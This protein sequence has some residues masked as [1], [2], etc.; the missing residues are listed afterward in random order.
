MKR[1]F[2]YAAAA[3]L[4]ALSI[5]LTAQGDGQSANAYKS[6]QY[7]SGN[8][9]FTPAKNVMMGGEFLWGHRDNFSDGFSSNDYRLQF[10]FKYSFGVKVGG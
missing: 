5:S 6:G 4:S 10:S 8:L 2:P 1:V 9:L 3:L 7:A